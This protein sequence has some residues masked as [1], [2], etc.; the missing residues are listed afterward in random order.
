MSN[1]AVLA[2]IPET[3]ATQL[4]NRFPNPG[5]GLAEYLRGRWAYSKDKVAWDADADRF[6]DRPLGLLRR[7]LR[8]SFE[9]PPADISL[10]DR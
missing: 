6:Q 2:M 7:E 3:G 10:Q 5:D 8:S 4:P 9:Q 1:A